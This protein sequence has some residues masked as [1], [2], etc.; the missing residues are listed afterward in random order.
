MVQ[1]IRSRIKPKHRGAG[2]PRSVLDACA[3]LCYHSAI[4][5][6]APA[7]GLLMRR[8]GRDGMKRFVLLALA[9]AATAWPSLAQPRP[10]KI[11]VL[12]VT[13]G[14]AF[15]RAPFFQMFSNMTA[16]AFLAAEHDKSS[17]SAWERDDLAAFQAVVLYDMPAAL[18]EAQKAKFLSLFEQGTGL[19]VL[20]HALASFQAW[21]DY[22][23][24][25]G[26]RYPQPPKGQPAVSDRVGYQHDV[27]L[28]VNVADNAHPITAGLAPFSIRD[29]IYW[30][31]RTGLDVKP[32]LTT[33]HAQSGNPLMWTRKEG[34]SRVVYLQLGHDRHA[35][36]N[37]AFRTLVERSITWAA[38]R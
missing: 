37:P 36:E 27:T 28:T 18:T 24:I 10:D 6:R 1:K 26:G 16:V 38:R 2:L 5:P 34:R 3:G 21:P 11:R 25:I 15:E 32:L 13:G 14:H 31:F 7:C 19:V 8:K 12:L 33:E 22:E 4:P 35:Y 29:E 23:R 20:H 9:A 17:A 30:G